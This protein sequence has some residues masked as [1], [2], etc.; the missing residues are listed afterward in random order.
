MAPFP[1]SRRREVSQC[2]AKWNLNVHSLDV[3]KQVKTFALRDVPL[4]E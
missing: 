3:H 1:G 2:T 4:S